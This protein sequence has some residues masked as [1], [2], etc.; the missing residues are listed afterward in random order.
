MKRRARTS[1]EMSWPLSTSAFR[2]GNEEQVNGDPG[3]WGVSAREGGTNDVSMC[4]CLPT[5]TDARQGFLFVRVDAVLE[6]L[7]SIACFLLGRDGGT[8]CMCRQ[9]ETRSF[10]PKC[11]YHVIACEHVGGKEA[12]NREERVTFLRVYLGMGERL[13]RMWPRL[14]FGN[15]RGRGRG[16]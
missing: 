14:R 15:G 13:L 3:V 10:S 6:N 5:A 12:R 11:R 8:S 2:A 7:L 16:C 4:T 9:G 1:A